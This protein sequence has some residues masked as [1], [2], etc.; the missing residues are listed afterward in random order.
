MISG[1]CCEVDEICTLLGYYTVYIVISLQMFW[2]NL[3][4]FLI[5]EDGTDRLSRNIGKGLSLY[6]V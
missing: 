6:A 2:D 1:F 4:G 5:L 3:P